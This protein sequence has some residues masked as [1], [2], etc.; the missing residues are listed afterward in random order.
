MYCDSRNASSDVYREGK[1]IRTTTE[2]GVSRAGDMTKTKG[3]MKR[4]GEKDNP[5]AEKPRG[6]M[7]RTIQKH[8]QY[9]SG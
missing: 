8:K 7:R 4:P 2:R 9:V 6:K 1:S 3:V 5:E